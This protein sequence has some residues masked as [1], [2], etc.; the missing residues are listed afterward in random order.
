MGHDRERERERERE[1]GKERKKERTLTK[2]KVITTDPSSSFL[3]A[4]AEA[5]LKQAS[6]I[7]KNFPSSRAPTNLG[8]ILKKAF[9]KVPK[10]DE[11]R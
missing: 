6:S 4:T 8:N 3:F 7:S 9:W 11:T 2:L 1:R 10:E 5:V